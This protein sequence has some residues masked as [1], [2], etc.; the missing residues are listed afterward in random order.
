M[1]TTTLL[2]GAALIA[3]ATAARAQDDLAAREAAVPETPLKTA[4]F[5]ELHVHTSYSLDAYIGGARLTPFDA[6]RFARGETVLLNGQKH[7][8]AKPLDFAAVTDHA[9]YIGEMFTVQVDGAPGHDQAAVVELREL[10]DFEAQEKW[11]LENF[12][13]NQ[14]SG[15]PT[16]MSF[17]AGEETTRSAWK[18][19]IQ[20]AAEQ[21]YEPGAFTT[22]IGFEWTSVIDGGNMHRNVLF[23]G[24]Q[25]PDLPFSSLDSADEE[26]LWEWMAVQEA[27]GSSKVLAIPHNSNGSKGYMFEPLDNSGNPL[28]RE[29]AETRSQ[30]EPLIEMMQIKGNSEVVASLWPADEFADFENAP[31]MQNY[32]DR[33]FKKENFVRWAVTKGLAY[34]EAF[35]ANPYKLGFV[36]GTDN[37]NGPPSDVVED[38]Q[39]GSHGGYDDTV[40]GRRV[41]ENRGWILVREANPGS[42]TGVWAPK[43]TRGAIWDAL[44]ARETFATSGTRIE[45][46]FFG[47]PG[48]AATADPVAL[49][50]QG[51]TR[52]VPMGGT[53]TGLSRAP[54]FNVHAMRDPRGANLDRTQI[55][56]GW[57]DEAGEPQERIVDVVWSGDREPDGDGK[58]PPVGSTVNLETAA[59][60][61]TIGAPELIGSWTDDDFDASAP[62]LYYVRVLEIPTPRWTTYDAVQYGLPLL[63]DVPAT[64]QERAWT[65]PIWYVPG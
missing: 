2:G 34:Q 10:P 27:A 62:A 60:T 58:L 4:L 46:R 44:K 20:V 54:S 30:W 29:Y 57:V 28:S 33:T 6:Y 64:I 65:S 51:Y 43:N 23:R 17:Y 59:Y 18:D 47:G 19:V 45:P 42:I 22:L 11:Y 13:A 32:N 1:R 15:D 36:G 56:K 7:N 5:G 14:R 25:V 16:H 40:E 63:E 61:N 35:G 39:I 21:F 48:L 41:N 24:A 9:E 53:L 3:L 55:I 52:G 8:I 38:N 50:E 37:H 12:Q 31:S 26:K 49:V